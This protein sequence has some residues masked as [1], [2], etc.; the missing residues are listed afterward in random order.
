MHWK[1][2]GYL[3]SKN[4]FDE[5]SIIIDVF[6]EEHGK[7]TGIVYGGLSRKHKGKFQVGNKFLLHWKSKGENKSGY[8]NTELITP[9]SPF[10]MDDKKRSV[11]ILSAA[12]ILKILLPERQINRKIY[13]SFE[14]M[15]KN[16]NSDNWIKIYIE[17]ELTLIKE[18]GFES[19]LKPDYTDGISKALIYNKNLLMKNF[20]IPNRLKFPLFRNILENYFL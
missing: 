5:N 19:A 8:F 10:F 13:I 20:I 14:E 1:D 2:Y 12:S 6:T 16:L 4:N 7:Y 15:L 3:L 17:W 11:C 9:I 18:L